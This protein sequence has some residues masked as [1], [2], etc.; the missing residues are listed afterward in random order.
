MPN[1]PSKLHKNDPRTAS[2]LYSFGPSSQSKVII[3]FAQKCFAILKSSRVNYKIASQICRG[4]GI[5]VVHVYYAENSA[6]ARTRQKRYSNFEIISK[7][8]RFLIANF[9]Y[10]VHVYMFA[11]ATYALTTIFLYL[12]QRILEQYLRPQ[13][14][15]LTLTFSK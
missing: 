10:Y 3:E 15:C 14:I 7:I 6:V 12:F 13:M 5:S 4:E 11:T 2:Y 8:L 9:I 1:L